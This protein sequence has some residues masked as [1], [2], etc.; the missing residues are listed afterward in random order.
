MLKVEICSLAIEDVKG[1]MGSSEV[2]GTKDKRRQLMR[3]GNHSHGGGPGRLQS[4]MN[5]ITR[6]DAIHTAMMDAI[7]TALIII[8]HLVWF[9]YYYSL[10]STHLTQ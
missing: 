1:E 10:S 3:H 2:K 7:L 8:H 9:N 4:L 5:Q 6:L